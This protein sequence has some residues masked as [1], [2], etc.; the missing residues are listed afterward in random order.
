LAQQHGCLFSADAASSAPLSE[1]G[2][3]QFFAWLATAGTG[4]LLFAN[5]N[6]ARVLVGAGGARGSSGASGASGGAGSVAGSADAPGDLALRIAGRCGQA[7]VK[8]GRGG[9]FWSDG[10]TVVHGA[11]EV[12]GQ[13][14]VLDSTGA[15]DAFAAGMLAALLREGTVGQALAAANGLARQAITRPGARPQ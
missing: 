12:V 14:D 2:A 15:G 9:A 13:S 1:F 4:T 7:V 3:E 8:C 6:E 10:S 5:L 11:A